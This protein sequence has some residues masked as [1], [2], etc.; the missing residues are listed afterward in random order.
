METPPPE[1]LETHLLKKLETHPPWKI[2]DPPCEQNHTRLWKYY[3]G[4]NFVSA[5]NNN[6]FSQPL[7]HVYILQI[8]QCMRCLSCPFILTC[9]TEILGIITIKILYL[10]DFPCREKQQTQTSGLGLIYILERKRYCLQTGSSRIQ[11]NIHIEQGQKSKKIIAFEFAF[12][13]GKLTLIC[14]LQLVNF[15]FSF[16]EFSFNNRHNWQYNSKNITDVKFY[17]NKNIVCVFVCSNGSW[18]SIKKAQFSI[19]RKKPRN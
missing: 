16:N 15:E 7:K 13:H 17:N 19:F 8:L 4:Q 12:D 14:S 6:W 1:K 3:L 5:G 10:T 18:I 9:K 11:I 2:G